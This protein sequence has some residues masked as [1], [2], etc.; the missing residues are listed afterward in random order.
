MNITLFITFVV[1]SIV[2]V[3]L[4][5]VKSIVTVKCGKISASVVNAV[6]FGLYTIVTVYTMC[7]L[8]LF[9][10]ALIVAICNLIGVYIVKSIEEKTRKD[11][12]WKIETTVKRAYADDIIYFL[13]SVNIPYNY[14]LDESNRYA[15][16]NVYCAT[17]AESASV[18][19]LVNRFH[20][21]YFASES[22]T[23]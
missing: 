21:K 20:A 12:L 8:P 5:T 19:E 14:T 6:A 17:Q 3:I 7:D 23:L 1:L 4:Q 2:N 9:V 10:K 18:K 22:K 15:I 13:D 16:F 11:K